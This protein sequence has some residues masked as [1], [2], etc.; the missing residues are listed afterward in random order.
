VWLELPVVLHRPLPADGTIR[1]AS[2]I[3]ER[4]GSRERWRL[5]IT[6]A[7]PERAIRQ[8]PAVALDLGWRL[9]PHGLR[10]AS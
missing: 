7:Q 5:L 2:V 9:L 3:C 10:V 6:V 1:S 8:G 4:V